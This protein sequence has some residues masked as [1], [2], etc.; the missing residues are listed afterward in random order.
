MSSYQVTKNIE[1]QVLHLAVI[2]HS[3][4]DPLFCASTM[5]INTYKEAGY[6]TADQSMP[7]LNKLL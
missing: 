6:T 3:R 4:R 1:E 2:Q 5:N 7:I